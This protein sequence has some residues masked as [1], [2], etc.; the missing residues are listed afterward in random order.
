MKSL[1]KQLILWAIGGLLYVMVELVWRGRSHWTMFV[2]GGICFVS[3]GLIN[4]VIPWSMKL[5]YQGIIGALIV[6][7]VEF[8]SGCII[9]IWL[10]WAVWDYSDLPLNLFGQICL[11]F[12][13]I[14]FFIALAAIVIDDYLRY[15]LFGEERPMYKL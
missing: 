11:P 12:T 9:N 14:W 3:I 5:R 6:I 13:I 1:A 2:V 7:V 4:E 15:W 8:I 10:G